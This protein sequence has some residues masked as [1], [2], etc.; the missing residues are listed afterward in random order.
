[1]VPVREG[2]DEFVVIATL[3]WT[4]RIVDNHRAT[5]PIRVLA[6]VM[7]VIPVGARLIEL[8]EVS[9]ELDKM[10]SR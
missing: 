5:E 10:L 2:D 6:I 3:I 8:V 4:I 1:M 7:R 9:L